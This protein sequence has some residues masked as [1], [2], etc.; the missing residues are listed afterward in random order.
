MEHVDTVRFLL[1]QGA[2]IDLLLNDGRSPKVVIEGHSNKAALPLLR[3]SEQLIE[4]AAKGVKESFEQVQQTIA[5]LGAGLNARRT[6]DGNTA[7]HLA[8]L[9]QDVPFIKLLLEKG[10]RFDI[11]NKDLMN[12]YEM[13][14]CSNNVIIKL[15]LN[16]AKVE[17]LAEKLEKEGDIKNCKIKHIKALIMHPT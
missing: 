16:V 10:A 17:Q 12:A 7:L 4:M 1:E 13:A 11:P 9:R 2:Y 5:I 6:E 15:M 3:A 14:E 8:I